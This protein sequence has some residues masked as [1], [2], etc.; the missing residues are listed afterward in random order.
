MSHCS[1]ILELEV[2]WET[3]QP[4]TLIYCVTSLSTMSTNWF[5][6]TLITRII[7]SKVITALTLGILATK[8]VESTLT[9]DELVTDLCVSS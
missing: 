3:M 7:T 1:L 5:L 4:I 8:V 6:F 2:K 9:M